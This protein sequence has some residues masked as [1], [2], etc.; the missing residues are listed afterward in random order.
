MM[1]EARGFPMLESLAESSKSANQAVY[2]S[3]ATSRLE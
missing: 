1:S 3:S 2:A